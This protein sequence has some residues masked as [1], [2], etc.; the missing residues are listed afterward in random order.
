MVCPVNWSEPEAKDERPQ[1]LQQLLSEQ[2]R[3]VGDGHDRAAEPGDAEGGAPAR[4]VGDRAVRVH[5][6]GQ[7]LA[8]RVCQ[9][10]G[11]NICPICPI[12]SG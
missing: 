1:A 10:A 12:R 9:V 8:Q 3:E 7:R 2:G 6:G 11:C 5:A 4:Q